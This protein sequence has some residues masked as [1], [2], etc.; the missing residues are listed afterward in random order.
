[1]TFSSSKNT[2]G[3]LDFGT[4]Q[5]KINQLKQQEGIDSQLLK[6]LEQYAIDLQKKLKIYNNICIES[7]N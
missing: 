6:N 5:Q 1:M 3:F 4:Y 7:W 2:D